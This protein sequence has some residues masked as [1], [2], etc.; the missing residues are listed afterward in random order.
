M[1]QRDCNRSKRSRCTS[2]LFA[3]EVIH[4]HAIMI[5][6]A[7]LTGW[8][9][10]FLTLPASA[11]AADGPKQLIRS[12]LPAVTRG[13]PLPDP[14]RPEAVSRVANWVAGSKNNGGLPYIVIDKQAARL[15]LF[16]A[17][18]ELRGQAPVLIGITT[19]DEATPGV[20]AKTLSQIGPAERTTPA[21]RFLARY[22]VAVGHK[23]VL[24]VDY[25]TSVALHPLVKG[26]S[27]DRRRERLL[28]PTPD[29]N[30]ITFGCIN[31]P[32]AFYKRNLSPLFR[33]K[34]GVVY[35]LPETKPIEEVFPR[36][37]LEPFQHPEASRALR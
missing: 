22:G 21:G 1:R 5:R 4:I 23:R 13:A 34:G 17:Q 29:D 27:R 12:A 35:I 3:D 30:R 16:D 19:G 14:P 33:R 37:R 20:G 10:A 15:F 25:A 11:Q 2:L 24:W 28:S 7:M 31:L 8:S 32:P 9:L 6:T 36:L 26:T 18:G